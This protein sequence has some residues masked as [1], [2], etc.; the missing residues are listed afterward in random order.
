MPV[1]LALQD[2]LEGGLKVYSDACEA[3]TPRAALPFDTSVLT[4]VH[5]KA[6]IAALDAFDAKAVGPSADRY[7]R[8]LKQRIDGDW[9]VLSAANVTAS[10]AW[11][12]AQ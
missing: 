2:A 4:A 8:E 1:S 9:A 3:E 7:R 5:E 6:R 11:L 10:G 12:S